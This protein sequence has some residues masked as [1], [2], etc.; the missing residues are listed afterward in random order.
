MILLPPML[1]PS[2]A[3]PCPLM[4]SLPLPLHLL[5]LHAACNPCPCMLPAA[6]AFCNHPAIT[7]HRPFL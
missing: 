5:P 4:L 7:Q 1:L 6:A 3:C 2:P